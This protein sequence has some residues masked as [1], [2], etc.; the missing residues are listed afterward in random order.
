MPS[1]NRP[2]STPL[3]LDFENEWVWRGDQ[4]LQLPPKAFAVLRYLVEHPGRL[5]G[6]VELFQTV[7][8]D[9]VVSEWALTT[10]IRGIRKALGEK[11]RE[12]QYIET[13]HRRGYR[14]IGPAADSQQSIVS[15]PFTFPTPNPQHPAPLLVGRE[16]ELARL[17]SQWEKAQ[18]GERQLIFVIGEPGIG[19]TAVMEAFLT[20]IGQQGTGNG[21]QERQQ[22]ISMRQWKNMDLSQP[23]PVA[24][25][26]LPGVWLGHGQCIEH[27]GAGEAYLPLLSALGHLGR[28]PDGHQL[29]G[30]LRQQAPTW[31]V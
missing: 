30:L 16:A 19:K 17:R 20:D 24:R 26:L 3:W 23:M 14:F 22:L 21:A 9:T 8:P 6:K 15:S 27:Y 25:S 31:L 13:V 5:V 2:R 7:W 1:E 29:I 11:A 4:C 12:P 18:H 10:C 28:G